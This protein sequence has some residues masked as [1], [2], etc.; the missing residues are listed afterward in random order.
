MNSTCIKRHEQE[1]L[2][3]FRVEVAPAFVFSKNRDRILSDVNR[4]QRVCEF[5]KH[6]YNQLYVNDAFHVLF[7]CPMVGKERTVMYNRL[8]NVCGASEWERFDTL[9]DLGISLLSPQTLDIACVVGRFLCE[10]LASR[11]ILL[12]SSPFSIP[13]TPV[14]SSKWTGGRSHKLNEL[15]LFINDLL[16]KRASSMAPLPYE[17]CVFTSTWITLHSRESLN[18]A[19]KPIRSWL[20]EGWEGRLEKKGK[21]KKR[22]M[23]C[24]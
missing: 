8:D 7:K 9:S 3:L 4:F 24:L 10:Y 16:S 1:A 19:F 21:S 14:A 11:D 2:S 6:V 13:P 5:C 17:S 20:S 15:S 18:D 23:A 12:A 22:S